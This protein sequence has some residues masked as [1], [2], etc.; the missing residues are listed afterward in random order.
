MRRIIFSL[1]LFAFMLAACSAPGMDELAATAQHVAA[2]GVALTLQAMP[3]ATPL[4]SATHTPTLQPSPTVTPL[5][6]T[7]SATVTPFSGEGTLA[8]NLPTEIS[9]TEMADK[10]DN[11]TVLYLQNNT[12]EVIWL[13][14]DSPTYLEYRFSD[15]FAILLPVGEYH[16]RVWIGGKGPREGTFRIGNHDKHTLS[17]SAGKVQFFGP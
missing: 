16:Y 1:L 17:F 11:S 4:P 5:Q 9:A 6:A 8:N 7:V 3:T 10:S 15:S 13:I 14:I 2:T 12:D